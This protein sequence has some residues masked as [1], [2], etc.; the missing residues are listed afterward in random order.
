MEAGKYTLLSAGPD[1]SQSISS[2]CLAGFEAGG[3]AVKEEIGNA[4]E[5]TSTLPL[6]PFFPL[7]FRPVQAQRLRDAQSQH[8]AG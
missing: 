3:G 1:E 7:G 2:L 8:S 4:N 5:H 6:F